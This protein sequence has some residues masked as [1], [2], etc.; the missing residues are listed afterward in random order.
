MA[1]DVISYDEWI[2]RIKDVVSALNG[3]VEEAVDLKAALEKGAPGKTPVAYLVPSKDV[4]NKNRGGSQSQLVHAGFDVVLAVRNV[5]DST[6]EAARKELQELRS[7]LFANLLG[8]TPDGNLYDETRYGGG[9]M[10][11]FMNKV[12]W[13]QDS[14]VTSYYLHKP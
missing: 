6:G 14:F 12:L 5:S 13:W 9:Q 11:S 7:V 10:V 4:P 3:R 2:Q 1:L 8:W